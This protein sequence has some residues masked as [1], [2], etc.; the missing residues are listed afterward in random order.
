VSRRV[1]SLILDA[2]PKSKEGCHVHAPLNH[3]WSGI[4][5]PRIVDLSIDAMIS[6][7]KSWPERVGIV[8]KRSIGDAAVSTGPIAAEAKDRV[9]Q[10]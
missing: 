2:R 9:E 8:D 5:G 4:Q 6:D 3:S 1:W 7:L 10:Y